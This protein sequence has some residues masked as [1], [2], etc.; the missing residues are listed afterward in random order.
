MVKKEDKQVAVRKPAGAVKLNEKMGEQY[1]LAMT[2]SKSKAVPDAYRGKPDE[3]F[4]SMEYG[5][6]LGIAPMLALANIAN[7]NG[8]PSCSTNL[9]LGLCMRHKDWRGYKIVESTD[10]K[11]KVMIYRDV[12]GDK[13]SYEGYFDWDMMKAARLWVAGG[14]WEKYPKSMMK[15]RAIAFALRDGFGDVVT[16]VYSM[17]EMSGAAYDIEAERSIEAEVSVE[18]RTVLDDDGETEKEEKAQRKARVN[19]SAA[20][21]SA[22]KKT[23]ASP[24]VAPQR[25]K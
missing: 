7:I 8:K 17:E 19:V 23:A 2:L 18:A 10:K 1:A 9:M 16:G 14:S 11:C 15:A 12:F 20:A 22:A 3:C 13:F 5:R 25:R 24:K 4:S 6:E 21:P